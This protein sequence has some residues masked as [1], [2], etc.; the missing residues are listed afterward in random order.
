VRECPGV[1]ANGA[2]Y[3]IN[4]W[5]VNPH[6]TGYPLNYLDAS[7]HSNYL[8]FQAEFRQRL[9]YGAQFNANYTWGRWFALAPANGYQANVA[10]PT[11]TVAALYLTDRNFRLNYGSSAFDVR[12]AVHGSGRYDLPFGQGRKFLNSSK[13]GN[14]I[15]GGWTLGTIVTFQTGTPVQMAGGYPTVNQNDAGVA[16]HGVT[17]RPLQQR[18]AAYHSGN[19]WVYVS[20]PPSSLPRTEPQPVP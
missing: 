10:S 13:L 14:E 6:T 9:T 7:G 5:E 4:F 1:T 18:V 20:T 19:P 15:L 12:Q 8:A 3:P 16:F 2:G 11:G 17:V